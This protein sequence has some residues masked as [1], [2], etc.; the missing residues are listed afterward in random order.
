MQLEDYL[1]FPPFDDVPYSSEDVLNK[2]IGTIKEQCLGSRAVSEW[3]E[4]IYKEKISGFDEI[5]FI[6]VEVFKYNDLI[7]VPVE[8]V[9]DVRESS[10]TSSNVPSRVFRNRTTLNRYRK[11]REAVL[12]SFCNPDK[13]LQIAFT[14]NPE[15]SPN[16]RL[17]A[18]LVVSVIAGRNS[19]GSTKYMVSGDAES[20][21]VDVDGF[22]E[23]VE[24]NKKNIGLIFGQTSY[25]Y[26]YLI[27]ELKERGIKIS[28]PETTFLYGWGWKKYKNSAVSDEEFRKDIVEI[29]GIKPENILD[30]YGFAES[31]TL[32]SV[33]EYGWRHVPRWERVVVRDTDTLECLP[34][35]REGLLQF[36]SP[37]PN[38][39]PGCS[40]LTDDIGVVRD[41]ES[42]QCGRKGQSFKVLRRAEGDELN[43]MR[44]VVARYNELSD[45]LLER[46]RDDIAELIKSEIID[47]G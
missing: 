16:P 46:R 10:G 27:K 7:T 4:V 30:M 1:K 41:L 45:S 15:L 34:N 32:Y 5:P 43:A 23:A 13:S 9:V 36:I 20:I 31:N 38:S 11:S 14:H 47:K 25:L 42:C 44:G 18:N 3:F 35:G 6:P 17:S 12:N 40:L 21:V 24:K 33:C 29:L 22:L 8:D 26:V 19:N 2:T 39:F 37:L 28:L